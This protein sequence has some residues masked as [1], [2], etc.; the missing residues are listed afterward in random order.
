MITFSLLIPSYNRPDMIR[1]AALSLVANQADDVEILVA[2]D[3]SPRQAEIRA[4]LGDLISAGNV[5]F[6]GHTQNRGWSYNRN[7]LVAAA[8]GQWVILM[9][10]DDRLKPGALHRLR[11]WLRRRPG[12]DAYAFGYDIIDPEGT[13]V[14]TR[15]SP[16]VV[17]YRLGEGAAWE[18]LF[19]LDAIPMWAHH[20][21]TMAIRRSALVAHPYEPGAGI[22]DDILFLFRVLMAGGGILTVPESLFEWRFAISAET[23]YQNLSADNSRSL[24][25]NRQIWLLLL[26][27]Q[28]VPAPVAALVRS[29]RWI[30]RFLKTGGAGTR[31]LADQVRNGGGLPLGLADPDLALEQAVPE[32]KWEQAGKLLRGSRVFGPIHLL[33]VARYYL[34]RRL[35]RMR[36]QELEARSEE[37][38]VVSN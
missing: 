20:P 30:R 16:K 10:D 22:G 29:P 18:E 19:Y 35:H 6:L 37:T 2:D 15:T 24:R 17:T 33:N 7:S 27:A 11:Q 28:N 8:Q 4:V 5:R 13:Y 3:A 21:F 1:E 14:Y 31:R 26:Q 36:V 12:Y 25:A 34:E 32:R 23:R 38:T 9:G